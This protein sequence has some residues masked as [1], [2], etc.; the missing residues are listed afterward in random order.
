MTLYKGTTEPP[1]PH[2]GQLILAH[3]HCQQ[4]DWMICN[5]CGAQF[6]ANTHTHPDHGKN[7]C[8]AQTGPSS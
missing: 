8:P 2:C 5:G 3:D 4:C 7:L 6:N 1:C